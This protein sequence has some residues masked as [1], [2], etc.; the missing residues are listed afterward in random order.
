MVRV[1][2]GWKRLNGAPSSP[3]R[4][5]PIIYRLAASPSFTELFRE[6][7]ALVEETAAYLDGPGREESRA[8]PTRALRV[9]YANESMRLTTRLMLL[10]SWLLLRRAVNEGELTEN[11]A[12]GERQRLD[13]TRQDLACPAETFE[14]LPP[15]L[16]ALCG[17][18]LRIQERVL[19]LDLSLVAARSP[20]A[21]S[22]TSAVAE[23]VERLRAVFSSCRPGNRWREC[24]HS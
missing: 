17:R 12:L 20:E 3:P 8:L 14:R 7:M 24:R 5:V 18:S 2:E 22:G 23:Q 10:A 6:G 15:A 21:W 19:C 11:E 13:L 9:G 16:Q 1:Y 4:A